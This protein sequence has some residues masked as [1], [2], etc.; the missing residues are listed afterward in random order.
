MS[1]TNQPSA[2]SSAH[3]ETECKR[4]KNERSGAHTYDPELDLRNQQF[5]PLKALY[6]PSIHVPSQNVPIYNN[7]AHF[8]SAMKMRQQQQTSAGGSVSKSSKIE[9]IHFVLPI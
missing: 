4:D 3:Q 9:A 6:A 8:E 7:L 2:S 5:N 1:D